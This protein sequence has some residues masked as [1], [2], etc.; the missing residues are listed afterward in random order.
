MRSKL[1]KASALA[2]AATMITTLFIAGDSGASAQDRDP[3]I[4]KHEPVT[5]FISEPVL[6]QLPA[7]S[8]VEAA[9]EDAVFEAPVSAASLHELVTAQ[10]QPGSLT[11]EMHC[12]AGAIY[13]ESRGESLDGQLAVG[14]VIVER[15]RSGRFPNSYCGVVFQR[16]QFSFVRGNS[17]PSIREGSNA[18]RKAVAVAQIAHSG[19]WQSPAE[20]ALFFH[21]TRVSPGWRLTRVARVDNHVFYR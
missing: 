17:M 19:S 16:S 20:G 3:Q 12:L 5:Q 11:R 13:F 14:R 10:P 8:E 9:V 1:Q 4:I 6:Q 2:V 7:E 18:W 21:A 15:A